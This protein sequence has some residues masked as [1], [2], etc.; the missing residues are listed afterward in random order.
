MEFIYQG[1]ESGPTE[2]KV[3]G[4]TF[5]SGMAVE[6]EDGAIFEGIEIC[7]K[8]SGNPNFVTVNGGV[9]VLSS[10]STAGDDAVDVTQKPRKTITRKKSKK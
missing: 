9:E 4:I 6:V 10:G 5:T 7:P 8:L 1:R 2:V 3:Y